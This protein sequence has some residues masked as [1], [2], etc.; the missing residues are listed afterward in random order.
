LPIGGF[1][2]IFG[3]NPDQESIEGI[4]KERSFVHKPKYIQAAVLVAGVAMNMLF[5][6]FLFSVAIIIGLP[7]PNGYAGDRELQ[8]ASVAIIG[9]LPNSPAQK[10]GVISG[11]KIVSI[12]TESEFLQSQKIAEIQQFI[13]SHKSVPLTLKLKR[14]DSIRD[15]VITPELGVIEGHAGVGVALGQVGTLKLPFFEAIYEAGKIT[16]YMAGAITIGLFELIKTALIG[17]AN[18]ADIAGPVGIV[19]MVGEA[20]AVGFTYLLGFAAMI[21]VNLAVLNL[22]PF[23]AL[24]GGR[25]L[26]VAIE[27]ISR[28]TIPHRIANALNIAGFAILILLMIAVTYSDIT[29]II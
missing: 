6:W 13:G 26:F 5:A 22:L 24:D 28:R 12:S 15:V 29:K 25:L 18:L 19:G 11:E 14:E 1:V 8:S 16:I 21:S 7:V 2:K 23:P 3:E 17:Q 4:D 20:S 27:A 10:A 9:V